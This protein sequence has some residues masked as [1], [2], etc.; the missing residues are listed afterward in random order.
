[1]ECRGCGM[2]IS[3][4][5]WSEYKGVVMHKFC[6][7]HAIGSGTLRRDGT[8]DESKTSLLK[9]YVTGELKL[10]D[11]LYGRNITT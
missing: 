10:G 2:E 6:I 1:M 3:D 7:V 4:D 5:G 11:E 9:R 8:I